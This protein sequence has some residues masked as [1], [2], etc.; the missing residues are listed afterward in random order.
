[1]PVCILTTYV[2]L[3][4]CKNCKPTKLDNTDVILNHHALFK[5]LNVFT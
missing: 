4:A 5:Q 1:M 2:G 3:P